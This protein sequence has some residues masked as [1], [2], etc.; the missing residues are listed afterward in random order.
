MSEANGTLGNDHQNMPS[1]KATNNSNPNNIARRIPHH[2][3][4]IIREIHLHSFVSGDVLS[5]PEY[6]LK[7]PA[8]AIAR[9]KKHRILVAN[10][11]PLLLSF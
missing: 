3:F 2:T 1:L 8:P 5:D 11:N 6:T 7:H 4:G 10:K 9:S